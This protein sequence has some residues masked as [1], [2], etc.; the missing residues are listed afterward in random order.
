MND[1]LIRDVGFI[2]GPRFH[3]ENGVVMCNGATLGGHCYVMKGANLGYQSLVHQRQV[4]G[5]Y[6][7]AH[8]YKNHATPTGPIL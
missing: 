2:R 6:L 7:T 1:K 5:S 8:P 4:I 3:V